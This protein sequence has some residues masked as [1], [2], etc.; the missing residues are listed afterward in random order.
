MARLLQTDEDYPLE[1]DDD[2]YDDGKIYSNENDEMHVTPLQS[3]KTNHHAENIQCPVQVPTNF[4]FTINLNQTP[5]DANGSSHTIASEGHVLNSINT[6]S[7]FSDT[8]ELV[9]KIRKLESRKH[10]WSEKCQEGIFS[11][12]F[13]CS[14]NGTMYTNYR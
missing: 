2:F 7:H 14:C 4:V 13:W 5:G 10:L 1:E 9:R 11:H 8:K 6:G 12:G 3:N